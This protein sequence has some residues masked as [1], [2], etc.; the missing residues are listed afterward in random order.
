M[1]LEKN[2]IIPLEITSLSNDGNGVGHYEGMAVFVAGAV[3]GDQLDIKLV[4]LCKSYAF[5]I[6]ERILSEENL[7]EPSFFDGLRDDLYEEIKQLNGDPDLLQKR[8]ERFRRMGKILP[9]E[10]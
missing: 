2:Q 8:Y 7:G 1:A 10:A 6:I 5:G 3:V 4:K 9:S